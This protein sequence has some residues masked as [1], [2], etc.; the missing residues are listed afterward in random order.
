MSQQRLPVGVVDTCPLL[1][2]TTGSGHFEVVHIDSS[3]E[4]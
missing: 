3:L 2:F 1:P 4:N